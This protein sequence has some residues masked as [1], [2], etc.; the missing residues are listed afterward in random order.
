MKMIL[1][2]KPRLNASEV[3]H[4]LALMKGWKEKYKEGGDKTWK[5]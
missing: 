1:E 2:I 5:N 3:Y 4:H